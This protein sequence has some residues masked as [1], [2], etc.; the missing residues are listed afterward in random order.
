MSIYLLPHL[1]A[2]SLFAYMFICYSYLTMT[3]LNKEK[4]KLVD[5]PFN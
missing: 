4:Q 5:V 2:Y 1:I 3:V